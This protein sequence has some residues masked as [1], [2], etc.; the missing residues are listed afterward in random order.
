MKDKFLF[1]LLLLCST[2]LFSQSPIVNNFMFS[3]ERIICLNSTISSIGAYVASGGNG[4]INYK[5]ISS[6]I[7]ASTGFA[8]APGINNNQFYTP[9]SPFM[10]TVWYRRV[11]TSG[12][13]VD[14]SNVCVVIVL[15]KFA[16]I[17]QFSPSAGTPTWDLVTLHY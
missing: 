16:N 13:F 2:Q 1:G 11:V 17:Q 4:T 14:T 10:D 6:N 12:T 9:P 7:G 3:N 5:W 15:S 8:A